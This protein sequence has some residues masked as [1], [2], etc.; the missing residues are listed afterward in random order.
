MPNPADVSLAPLEMIIVWPTVIVVVAPLKVNNP[1]TISSFCVVVPDVTDT[2]VCDPT[3]S[4]VPVWSNAPDVATPA[5]SASAPLISDAPDAE[6]K[7]TVSAPPEI[8]V[9]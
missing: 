2:A 7:V 5:T 1:I 9:T 6:L 4:A 3:E 8:L